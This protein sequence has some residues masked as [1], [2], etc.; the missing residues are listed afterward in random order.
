MYIIFLYCINLITSIEQEFIIY[1]FS[2]ESKRTYN[3]A[4]TIHSV[5]IVEL[6]IL[7]L[8]VF[9]ETFCRGPVR[10]RCIG[11]AGP[12]SLWPKRACVASFMW[13][14]SAPTSGWPYLKAPKG[15]HC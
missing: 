12:V 9:Q 2:E 1:K 15:E 10:G 7:S 11:T 4:C 8:P 13:M 5:L 3:R 14:H 6:P